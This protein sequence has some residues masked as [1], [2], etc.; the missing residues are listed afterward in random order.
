MEQIIFLNRDTRLAILCI[1]FDVYNNEVQEHY[2][3]SAEFKYIEKCANKFNMLESMGEAAYLDINKACKILKKEK[4]V[5][6]VLFRDLISYQAYL[7]SNYNTGLY[8]PYACAKWTI[9]KIDKKLVRESN[10]VV[11]PLGEDCL[12]KIIIYNVGD[13]ENKNLGVINND[14]FYKDL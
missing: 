14:V 13:T 10:I 5:V 2:N 12:Q 9:E 8:L 7:K 4:D 3:R 1:M 11:D 6:K